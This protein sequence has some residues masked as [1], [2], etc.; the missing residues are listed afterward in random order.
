MRKRQKRRKKKPKTNIYICKCIIYRKEETNEKNNAH[1]YTFVYT[2]ISKEH[3][4][5]DSLILIIEI[6]KSINL[7]RGNTQLY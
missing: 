5:H 3:T 7:A 6:Q 2:Y 4:L 1:I